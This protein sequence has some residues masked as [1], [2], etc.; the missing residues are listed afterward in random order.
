MKTIK[1]EEAQHE[2]LL[3]L[4]IDLKVSTINEVI[5]YLLENKPS[6]ER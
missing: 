6:V 3:R 1:V 2:E 5:I 4:K